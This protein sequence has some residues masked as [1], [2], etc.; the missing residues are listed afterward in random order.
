MPQHRLLNHRIFSKAIQHA[1][2]LRTL[3]GKYKC[4]LGHIIILPRVKMIYICTMAAPQVNP[5]PTPSNNTLW[6][7]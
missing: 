3:P 1:D 4:K 6:P 5:P 7:G 2:R